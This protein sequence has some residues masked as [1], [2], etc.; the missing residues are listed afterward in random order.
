MVVERN[1]RTVED[2]EHVD[3]P[4]R[5]SKRLAD[6]GIVWQGADSLTPNLDGCLAADLFQPFQPA[7]M[8]RRKTADE[9]NI[10]RRLLPIASFSLL[11]FF[12]D[13]SDQTPAETA[14]RVNRPGESAPRNSAARRA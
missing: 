2:V 9:G 7:R 8:M 13:E 14:P 5:P 11:Q 6:G 1:P 3:S 12:Q 4:G 10:D